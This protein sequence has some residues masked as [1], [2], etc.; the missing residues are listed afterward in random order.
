MA[1]KPSISSEKMS[2]WLMVF[3]VVN[4]QSTLIIVCGSGL[5]SGRASHAPHAGRGP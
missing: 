5:T 3:I 4:L 1:A 2:R